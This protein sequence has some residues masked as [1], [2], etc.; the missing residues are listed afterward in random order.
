MNQ[1]KTVSYIFVFG[2]ILYANSL[3]G[4]FMGDDNAFIV[5][6]SYIKSPAHP[7]PFFT[8]PAA[9]AEGP[10]KG[11]I[12]RPLTALS[13][14]LDYSVWKLNPFGYHLTNIIL[15]A[16][17]GVLVFFLILL[18][19]RNK[20]AAI[21]ASL[22][23]L[24]HPVQ[25]EAVSW[26]AGRANVLFLF[27]YCA[28]LIAYITASDG[29]KKRRTYAASVFLF[30]LALF[31]KEMAVTLPLILAVYELH[32]AKRTTVSYT[33]LKLAPFIVC[34]VFF[35]ALRSSVLGKFGQFEGWGDPLPLFYTMLIVVTD[36]LR[37]V[38]F[39]LKLHAAN[40]CIPFAVSLADP[41]VVLSLVVLS[42]VA[43]SLP[44]LF[45][46]SKTASFAAWWFFIT[47]LPV[48]NIIPIKALESERFLYLPSIGFVALLASGAALLHRKYS[49]P[50][51]GKMTIAVIAV[52]ILVS[53]Y[54]A[55]TITR[56]EDWEDAL[57]VSKKIIATYPDDVW[58]LNVHAAALLDAGKY[59]EAALC[60][61]KFVSIEQNDAKSRN[62]LGRCYL[63]L[64][65]YREAVAECNEAL[66]IDPQ[67]PKTRN[68]LGI[69]YANIKQY[70]DAK[71]QFTIAVG[72]NPEFLDPYL[73]L[74]RI[75]EAEGNFTDAVTEYLRALEHIT[76]RE[77]T[78]IV[79]IRAGDAYRMMSQ[80]DEAKKCYDKVRSLYGNEI[81]AALETALKEKEQSPK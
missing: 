44:F 73:N 29:E 22:L 48:L 42:A 50:V 24:S 19:S 62:A 15:H 20:A 79:Y 81:P 28:S 47:L 2:L 43:V 51:F 77:N 27:F 74:G 26:S 41:R 70:A 69:A 9:S 12:Y 67:Q 64:G 80:P 36:Y 6:N 10:L 55:R 63:K 57:T 4:D 32:F 7:A 66:R 23:F 18:I 25:T 52:G 65:K 38:F 33:A 54:S 16:A 78:A 3:G 58:A 37:L 60:Y 75:Y 46:R 35:V 56:N 76:G 34:A 13:F 8:D 49:R 39:P 45:K 30:I 14:A 17:N 40:Y 1:L 72:T 61:R 68:M 31:S 53:L 21:V 59:A 5:Y 11:D 71:K